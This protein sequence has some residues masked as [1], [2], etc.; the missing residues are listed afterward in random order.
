MQRRGFITGLASLI[1]AP[2]I[3]K[4][5]SL[6]KLWLPPPLIESVDVSQFLTDHDAW[7]F[8]TQRSW[9]VEQILPGV[10]EMFTA[11]GD[12]FDDCFDD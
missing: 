7:F 9:W 3:V 11:Q 12:T 10:R 5:E 2:A 4:P 1:A 8:H 6:M